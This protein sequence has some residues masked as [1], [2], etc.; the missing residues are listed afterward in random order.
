[1]TYTPP[2]RSKTVKF[3]VGR[4]LKCD[5]HPP[6]RSK[7]VKFG[8]G[9]VLKRSLTPPRNAINYRGRQRVNPRDE[10]S[11]QGIL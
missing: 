2:D 9:R 8:V 10:K 3:G 6:D 5:L 7:T 11:S 1:M 4:V